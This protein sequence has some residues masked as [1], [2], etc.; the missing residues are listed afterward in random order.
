M[1][2]P[3]P[4][5]AVTVNAYVSGAVAADVTI[6]SVDVASPPVLVSDAGVKVAVQPAGTAGEIL[7]G[8]VQELPLPLKFTVTV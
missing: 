8:D 2:I 7:R 4:F 6:F 1:E 5:P 3:P